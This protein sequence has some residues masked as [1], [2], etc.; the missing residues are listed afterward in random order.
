VE[1]GAQPESLY[2]STKIMAQNA[3]VNRLYIVIGEY[4]VVQRLTEL[5]AEAGL[6]GFKIHKRVGGYCIRPANKSIVLLTEA[7]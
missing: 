2:Y 3:R 5:Y 6:V 7:A 1:A 4:K